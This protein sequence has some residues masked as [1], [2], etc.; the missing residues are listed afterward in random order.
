LT[1]TSVF[2]EN[3]NPHENTDS[4]ITETSANVVDLI[5]PEIENPKI[6][7][8]NIVIP[9]LDFSGV[10][11]IEAFTALIRAYQLSFYLDSSIVGRINMRLDNVSLNDAILFIIKENN[12]SW[13]RTGGIVKIYKQEVVPPPPP[14]L[15]IEFEGDRISLNLN[16]AELSRF[17]ETIINLTGENIII[18]E[19]ARGNLTG[20]LVNIEFEKGLKAILNSNGFN[21]SKIDDIH[22]I[23]YMEKA[24][25]GAKATRYAVYCKNDSV[26]IDVRNAPI[27]NILT[28]LSDECQLG[29]IA[30]GKIEGTITANYGNQPLSEVLGFILRGTPYSFKKDGEIFFVGLK[31]SED[32]YTS[33]LIKLKHI[34][35]LAI[36]ELIP[37]TL[38]K[39]VTIKEAKE[40]NGIVVTGPSTSIIEIENFLNE[41]DIPP[42][43]VLFEAIVVDYNISEFKEFNLTAD[44]TGLSRTLPN[45]IYYPDI[46]YSSTGNDLNIH[47]DNVADYLNISNIGHLSPDFYLRLK[48]MEEEGIANVSSQPQIAALNGHEASIRIG[49]SQ[50]YLLESKTIYPSQQTDVSTQTS[51]R[52]EVIEAD[53]SLE[54]TPWVTESGDVIVSIQPEFNTP[55]TS[56]NPDIPPTINHRILKSTVRLKDGETIVLGGM[57]RNQES[58]TIRKFPLLGDLPIIGRLFQN[59]HSSNTQSK[60]MVYLTPHIYYGSEG[61][62]DIQKILDND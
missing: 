30:H 37:A 7:D 54:V 52:F 8:T 5:K 50:Y 47:L 62:V 56:F 45:Q 43:Q 20:R 18:D 53:M 31:N 15:D 21:V 25:D 39:Q 23:G 29:I 16:N 40:H 2:A 61:A 51:Q 19:G 24:G 10:T 26:T 44:N 33:R 22:H 11:L 35:Y 38:T 4:T 58:T 1:T 41:V 14:P 42:A 48:M 34:S 60:L 9:S 12:L 49:T 36:N 59:R 46:D 17:V 32:L 27:S 3:D 6:V 57:I 13:E 55:A 28:T